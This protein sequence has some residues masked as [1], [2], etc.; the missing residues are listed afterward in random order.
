MRREAHEILHDRDALRF[1]AG[2]GTEEPVM[3][4][5]QEIFRILAIY[6][7]SVDMGLLPEFQYG[8]GFGP[9]KQ[10]DGYRAGERQSRNHGRHS[11][12]VSFCHCFLPFVHSHSHS[13]FAFPRPHPQQI[14]R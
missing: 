13:V 1:A 8:D 14:T 7:E 6:G 5:D 3:G 9:R 11:E 4:G 10:P 12:P 2:A